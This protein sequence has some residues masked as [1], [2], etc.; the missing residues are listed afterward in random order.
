MACDRIIDIIRSLKNFARTDQAER[1]TVNIH[2]GLDSTLTL[3]HP[4][5]EESYPDRQGVRR[6]AGNIEF[7][8][9]AEPDVHDLLCEREQA[10]QRREPNDQDV[11]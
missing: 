11:S 10:C 1:K 9:P 7:I 2:D 4:S 8:Q 5:V 3:V 6:S